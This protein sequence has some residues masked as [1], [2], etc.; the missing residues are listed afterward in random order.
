MRQDQLDWMCG[1]PSL[2]ADRWS[3]SINAVRN[4]DSKWDLFMYGGIGLS[5]PLHVAVKA[6]LLYSFINNWFFDLKSSA[7][8]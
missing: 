1:D 3:C 2:F 8:S 7:I 5:V 4:S 6:F